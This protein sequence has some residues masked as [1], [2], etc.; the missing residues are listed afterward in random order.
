METTMTAVEMT[1]SIDENRQLH[2]DGVLPV[3]GP[4]PVRVI[5]LY[6]ASAELDEIQ[7]LQ[8][9]A[10]NPAFAFLNDPEEDIYTLADGKP[11]QDEV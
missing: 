3:S 8:A 9:A 7:W 11:V 4:I 2:L 6:S 1:G 5:V 10:S